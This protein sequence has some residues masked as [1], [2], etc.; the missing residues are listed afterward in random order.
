LNYI[1]TADKVIQIKLNEVVL[2]FESL[3]E[4]RYIKDAEILK[5]LKL[6]DLESELKG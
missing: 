2:M 6:Q 1:P 5:L 4:Q 3:K